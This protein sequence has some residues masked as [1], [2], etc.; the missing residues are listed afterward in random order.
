M[1]GRSE[2]RGWPTKAKRR[3]LEKVDVTFV[4]RAIRGMDADGM[5]GYL[6]VKVRVTFSFPKRVSCK[7]GSVYQDIVKLGCPPF[8]SCKRGSVYQDIVKL[9]CPPFRS[10]LGCPPF[11][12]KG[13]QFA[14]TRPRL[15]IHPRIAEYIGCR[16]R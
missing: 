11:R 16:I 3:K 7:R 13:I 5:G 15:I 12:S 1:W 14:A 2:G 10:Q 8:R 9:G 4:L 6:N